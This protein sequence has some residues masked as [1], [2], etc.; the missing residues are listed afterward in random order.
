MYHIVIER[1]G[2]PYYLQHA[3][4]GSGQRIWTVSRE[5]SAMFTEKKDAEIINNNYIGKQGA[6]V[7]ILTYMDGE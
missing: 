7:Q 6:V 1:N 2:R 4:D 3:G 5:E